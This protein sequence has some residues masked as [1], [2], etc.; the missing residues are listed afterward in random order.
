MVCRELVRLLDD[1]A[2]IRAE[3]I[4]RQSVRRDAA[5]P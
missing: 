1:R 4:R 5:G 2:L 3:E